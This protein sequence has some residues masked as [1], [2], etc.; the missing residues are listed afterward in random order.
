MNIGPEF[1]N[2]IPIENLRR[3]FDFGYR[4]RI[5]KQIVLHLAKLAFIEAW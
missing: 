5:L 1:L 2:S 3:H 4:T